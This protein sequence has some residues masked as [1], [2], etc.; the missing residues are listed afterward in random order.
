MTA[1]AMPARVECSFYADALC[2]VMIV[3]AR[4]AVDLLANDAVALFTN[5]VVVLLLLLPIVT[6]LFLW[7]GWGRLWYQI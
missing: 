2:F 3:R 5:F 1:K 7:Y 6:C 4:F